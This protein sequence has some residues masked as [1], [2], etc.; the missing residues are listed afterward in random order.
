MPKAVLGEFLSANVS[1]PFLVDMVKSGSSLCLFS[2]DRICILAI[3]GFDIGDTAEL[4][5]YTGVIVSAFFITQFITSLLWATV[6]EKHGNRTVLFIS[7]LGNAITCAVF[8]TCK[9]FPQA[10]VVR[11][12]QGVF[13]G[14]VGYV[15]WAFHCKW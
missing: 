15:L 3:T 2:W 14:A 6:A 9:S 1:T 5:S 11:L 4:G 8:G 7:L 12:I 10:V 13:N